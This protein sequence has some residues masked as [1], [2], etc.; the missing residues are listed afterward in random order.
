MSSRSSAS[1]KSSASAKSRKSPAP[2][3]ALAAAPASVALAEFS[4][5]P[6]GWN[7]GSLYQAAQTT[8]HREFSGEGLYGSRRPQHEEAMLR[9]FDRATIIARTRIMIRNNP[10]LASTFLAYVQEVGSPTYKST[11][12]LATP[13]ESN[14]YND[15]R[16]TVLGRFFRDI[17]N[18][19]DLSLA[20]VIEIYHYELN[21]AGEMFIIFLKTGEVQLIPSELCG[22]PLD[23]LARANALPVGAT[24]ADGTPLPAGASERDGIVRAD[25]RI[26]GYRFAQ[27]DA[28]TGAV[29]FSDP[30]RSTIVD[31][32]YVRHLY[33][34]DRIE[35]G[36]GVP[37]GA[38]IL[39]KLQDLFETG[40]ARSQQVKNAACLSMWITK[41]IDPNGFAESMKGAMRNNAVQDAVA[42]KTVAEQRSAYT[43][44]RAGAVY[45]G[46]TGE[47]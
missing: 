37:R 26:I 25:G 17:E 18:S 42:L 6:T 39:G 36:R 3:A 10:W 8:R 15:L 47:S 30:A 14:T 44:L 40:D 27:R 43:E 35:Q 46:A 16:E 4:A 20:D 11:A 33:D 12:R 7:N 19:A 29:N 31:A 24:F 41:N 21:I 22:S 45:Y 13:D 9:P 34:P 5:L 38:T 32:R 23:A 28:L 1:P 2:S